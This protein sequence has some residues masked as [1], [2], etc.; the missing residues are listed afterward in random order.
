[1][2][3]GN[4]NAAAAAAATAPD[5]EAALREQVLR[6]VLSSDVLNTVKVCGRTVLAS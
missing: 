2:L 4:E 1:M 6:H 3:P 5:R